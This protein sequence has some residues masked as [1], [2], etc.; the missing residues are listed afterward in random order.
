MKRDWMKKAR[1]ERGWDTREAALLLNISPALYSMLER[2]ETITHPHIAHDIVKLYNAGVE[3]YNGMVHKTH[4]RKKL[5][6]RSESTRGVKE[7][8]AEQD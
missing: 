3:E 4:E 5:L 1:T 6:K 8:E 2:G 7:N